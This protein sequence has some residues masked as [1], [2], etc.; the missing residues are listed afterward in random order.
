MSDIYKMPENFASEALL[1][2]E[3]YIQMYNE[4]IKDPVSFWEKQAKRLNWIRNFLGL[5]M[6]VMIKITFS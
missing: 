4:S 5:K 1:D 2:K 3:K 6:L